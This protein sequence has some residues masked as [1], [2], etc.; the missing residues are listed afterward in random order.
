[1]VG[2]SMGVGPWAWGKRYGKL[3]QCRLYHFFAPLSVREFKAVSQL[4]SINFAPP[5]KHQSLNHQSKHHLNGAR[6]EM[7][8]L[9][10]PYTEIG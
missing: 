1:M 4:S 3:L 9:A 2:R 8:M 7:S 6:I 10:G 5:C